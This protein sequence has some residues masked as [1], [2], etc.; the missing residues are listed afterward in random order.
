MHYRLL[1]R[2]GLRLSE[3]A[4]GSWGIGGSMWIGADDTESMKALR[5]AVD[6]GINFFDTAIV[7]GNGH[8]ETLI[9]KLLK[10][11]G[12]QLHVA[13]KIPP[14]NMQWPARNG[15]PSHEAFTKN[16]IIESTNRSLKSLRRECIDLQQLHVWRDDWAEADEIWEAIETLKMQGKINYFGI[17]I[18]DHDPASALKAAQTGK[19]DS[20]QVIYNIFDQSPEDELFPLCEKLNIGII[21]RVPFDEGGLTGRITPSTTFPEKDWRNNYFKGDRKQEIFNRVEQLKT[22]LGPEAKTLPELA[23][24]FCLSHPAVTSVIPG[25]RTVAHVEGNAEASKGKPL[26]PQL[27]QALR[28]FR[29]VRNFYSAG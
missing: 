2:T 1:G 29:W 6:V 3:I 28:R 18:N 24:R 4:F 22:L 14:K 20:F 11:S 15:V 16:H 7:Y 10:E 23:L 19:V 13:T 21:V 25:M 9:G 26:S 8:S 5:R 12:Q 27:I 17:S